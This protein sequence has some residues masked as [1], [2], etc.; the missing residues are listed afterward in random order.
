[1]ESY[2]IIPEKA[3]ERKETPTIVR[4]YKEI[5]NERKTTGVSCPTSVTSAIEETV[6][7]HTPSIWEDSMLAMRCYDECSVGIWY[8]L[9]SVWLGV[10]YG[11]IEYHLQV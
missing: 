4:S 1:M 5:V 8:I 11:N 9:R 10:C 6:T 2:S 7:E 3:E